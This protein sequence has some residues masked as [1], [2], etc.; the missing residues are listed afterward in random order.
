MYQA[1]ADA[2]KIE[3]RIEREARFNQKPI[4]RPANRSGLSRWLRSF[5][6]IPTLRTTPSVPIVRPAL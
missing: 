3:L 4:R 5:Q 2:R 6:G 1:F